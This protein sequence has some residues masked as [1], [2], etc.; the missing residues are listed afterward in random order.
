MST[1]IHELPGWPNLDW[2][3]ETLSPRLA[4]VRHRQ[5][6]LIGRLE[7]LGFSE[8][9]QAV[10]RTLTTDVLTS[11]AIEGEV[12]DADQVR[13]SVARRL[14]LDIGGLTAADRHVEG[15]VEMMLDAT[16]A[17]DQP[18][19]DERLFAWHAAMFPTGRSGMHRITVGA[20]RTD[21][22]SPMQVVSGPVGR[23]RVHFEAPAA[24]R[25]PGEM[26]AFLGWFNAPAEGDDPVM[27]A[28]QAHF[29]FV[30][31]HPF[32]DGNGRIARAIA[33]MALARGEGSPRRF[34]S[35]SAEI[36]RQRDD[37][38]RIL[39]QTQRGALDI[40][41]WMAWFLQCLGR[42]IDGA[43]ATLG[44]VLD[45]ARVWER[46]RGVALNERQRTMI[47]RLLDGFDGKLTTSKWA[48]LTK[49]SPDT[50]LRDILPLVAAGILVKSESGGRS[51]SYALAPLD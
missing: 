25:L 19:T 42:A 44:G 2:N 36:R 21:S 34:Y 13:S 38:Y 32:D 11:S 16:R 9:D 49:T 46:L 23:E 5:G 40:T 31:V 15:V 35:M 6:R 50:A 20:W 7:A 33:D 47:T 39:E 27:R 51:T 14:G 30:T 10:L 43:Q 48:A 17:F 37:Y 8:Q 22:S 12:L 4:D 24:S 26:R 3:R 18:L 28:A 1:Y 41:P 29:W 45:R